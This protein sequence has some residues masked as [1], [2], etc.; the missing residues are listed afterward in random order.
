MRIL[1]LNTWG[2]RV[3]DPLIA[4]LGQA[5]A[6][7]FCLQEMIHTPAANSAWLDYRDDG[8]VLPQRANLFTEVSAELPAHRGFFCAAAR[9][10]LYDGERSH[11]SEWGLATFV[12]RTLPVIGQAQD[13]VH[14]AFSAAGFGPHPRSRIAHAVRLFDDGAGAPVTVAHMHGLR[15]LAGKGD[16]PARHAQAKAFVE[17]IRRIARKGERLVV[18]GDFNVLP[19]SVML[20]ALQAIG[21]TD[22]VTSGGHTDTRT[23]LYTKPGRHANYM[24]VSEQVE[25]R[26]FEVVREPEVSD[27]RALL[28]EIA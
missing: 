27:H 23:S 5:D 17:L 10:P 24:L 18:C 4:W 28:L 16:T 14:G 7:V 15:E 26:R 11:Q 2:G 13:F 9:G 21:L 19:D 20:Q 8:I 25:V 6:D 3:G 12:R 22:L 1:S